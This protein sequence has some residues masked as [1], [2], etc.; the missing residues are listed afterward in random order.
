MKNLFS[1]FVDFMSVREEASV[2]SPSSAPAAL[3]APPIRLMPPPLKRTL[4]TPPRLLTL[5]GRSWG[6]AVSDP[7]PSLMVPGEPYR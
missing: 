2:K 1:Q 3:G 4:R 7:L 6:E 5:A